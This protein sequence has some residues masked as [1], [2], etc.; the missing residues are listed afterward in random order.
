M[1]AGHGRM[2]GED[3]PLDFSEQMRGMREGQEPW[4]QGGQK[5]FE[6]RMGVGF[7]ALGCI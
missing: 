7:P 3:Q 2:G 5:S 6:H 4:E 1:E